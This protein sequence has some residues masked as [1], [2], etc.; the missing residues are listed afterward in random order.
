MLLRSLSGE[1]EGEGTMTSQS[2]GG[3]STDI[4]SDSCGIANNLS[5]FLGSSGLRGGVSS[6][7][8]ELLIV[9]FSG[10]RLQLD[11]LTFL[12]LCGSGEQDFRYTTV[13][14]A[15]VSVLPPESVTSTLSNV[16]F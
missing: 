13:P 8:D 1:G 11:N 10:L 16:T 12:D 5:R 9:K 4:T 3:F 6:S 7:S 15:A 14:S 2:R